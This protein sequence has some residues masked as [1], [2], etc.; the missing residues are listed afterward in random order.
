MEIKNVTVIGSGIMGHGIAEVVALSGM[1]VTLEDI[2]DEILNR[3]KKSLEESLEK[4]VK[5]GKLKDKNEVMSRISFSTDMKKAVENADMVIEAVPE[6]IDLKKKVFDQLDSYCRKDA[7]LATNTSN[8]RLSEIAGSISKKENV[9]GMHFFNPPVVLKLVE[10]IKSDF[11]SDAVFEA[12]YDFSKKI[13]KTPIKVYKDTPGFVVNRINA[14][15]S[16]FFCLLLDENVGKPEEID[17]F[18]RSQG[19]PMGPYELMD[20]V[21][22][23]T[24]FHSLEYYKAE[25]S[26]DYGKCQ[27]Y[28]KLFQDKKLGLKTGE[29][30]YKWVNGKAQMP[31][32][33][34]TNKIDMMDV[35][36][37]EVN[38]AVKIIEEG[39]AS[40]D[41]I[42][43]GVRLGMNRPFGPITVAKG[44]TNAE[45]KQ[46]LESLQKR[47]GVSVFAPAKSIAEGKLKTIILA[48][49]T[50]Q[51]K[52]AVSQPTSEHI[53]SSDPVILE[54]IGKI[55]RLRIN[56]T[57]NNLVN[58]AV[59]ESLEKN[60]NDL[61]NDREIAVIILTGNGNVFSAGAQL[62]SFFNSTFDFLEYSRKGERIYKL[63]TEIPKITIAEMKGY[64]LG[65]GLEM[66]LACDIRVSTESV[67]IGFP[68]VTLGLI[69][70]W[71]GSQRLP[72][73]IGQSRASYII[74]TGER[75]S[76]KYAYEIGLVSKIFGEKTIDEDTLNFGK[77]LAEKVA[78]ISA[79]LAKRLIVKGMDVSVDDGLEMESMSMGVLYGTD[80]LKEGISAFLSKRKPEYKGK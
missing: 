51:K 53:E 45:I 30:F 47:F 75:F 27:T 52:E 43:T 10:V 23:D 59:M 24:V 54:R 68:E 13:G 73:L 60:L 6:I 58:A 76:G 17:R 78:P 7:I 67:Q 11:T 69:P 77:D 72:K 49:V 62:D 29:G 38:E 71:G 66:S 57:K 65:G 3:A 37:L 2:S 9:V 26:P 28:R 8:I 63:L 56:N 70:G 4:L 25:L 18:A 35:L 16:L 22:I 48:K 33:K 21:G 80:D 20:Y 74:L 55:A 31:D 50:P 1:D 61:W 15:E 40:P 5:S 12:T 42:E 14:P 19:L 34:P 39:V 41:D 46:K 36:S 64:T 44:L 32:A 79:A